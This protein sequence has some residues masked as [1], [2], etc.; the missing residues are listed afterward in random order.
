MSTIIGT[1]QVKV[2]EIVYRGYSPQNPGKI[3]AIVGN[4]LPYYICKVRWMH[5]APK[6]VKEPYP[7]Y[8]RKGDDNAVFEKETIE[9]TMHLNSFQAL[10]DDHKKKWTKHQQMLT[11]AKKL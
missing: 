10:I 7:H 8:P 11:K 9:H 4:D 5:P 6:L 1:R 3:I 2:G